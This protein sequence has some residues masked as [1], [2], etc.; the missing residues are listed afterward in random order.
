MQQSM[1][2][3]SFLSIL[4]TE[5][6]PLLLWLKGGERTGRAPELQLLLSATT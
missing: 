1:I 2:F 6:S 5:I 4:I 3:S